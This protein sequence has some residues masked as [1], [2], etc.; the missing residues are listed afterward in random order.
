VPVSRNGELV[1]LPELNQAIRKGTDG[2][3]R[4]SP[5]P[6]APKLYS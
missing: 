1:S 6:S 5:P 4:A 2:M 3:Q